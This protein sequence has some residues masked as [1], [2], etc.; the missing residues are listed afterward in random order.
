MCHIYEYQL[1]DACCVFFS[2]FKFDRIYY[3]ITETLKNRYNSNF[4]LIYVSADH[5]PIY[6]DPVY[7]NKIIIENKHDCSTN[8][9]HTEGE[10]PDQVDSCTYELSEFNEIYKIDNL[11]P[12]TS[13]QFK[14]EIANAFGISDAFISDLIESKLI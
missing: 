5:T 3:N 2:S 1:F 13:Y 8:N 11:L 4:N 7:N 9:W 10:L 14:I 6:E 12:G